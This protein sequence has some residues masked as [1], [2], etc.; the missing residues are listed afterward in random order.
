M[1][2]FEPDRALPVL[3]SPRKR[4][5]G[6][7]L[8]DKALAFSAEVSDW[9]VPLDTE[10]VEGRRQIQVRLVDDVQTIRELVL[11]LA[12][13][14]S[15]A[16]DVRFLDPPSHKPG[17]DP[18]CAHRGQSEHVRHQGGGFFPGKPTAD[19]KIP[20]G[21]ATVTARAWADGPNIWEAALALSEKK[22]PT[23][24]SVAFVNAVGLASFDTIT[25]ELT[26]ADLIE[27]GRI[28]GRVTERSVG[29]PGLAVLLADEKGYQKAATTTDASGRYAIEDVPA[30]KYRV[31]SHNS[32]TP[33][34]ADAVIE[35]K[36]G[37]LTTADLNLL[38]G[39]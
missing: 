17:A 12:L 14:R 25:I 32:A 13:D 19:G 31:L 35:V 5:I 6:F 1:V 21:A 39:R 10:G 38:Y 18:D 4:R 34:K 23:E 11:P 22:G 3:P 16:R 36:A 24:L 26:D 29:Q 27:P 7:A 37:K 9:V 15:A 8:R 20:A 30:G 2:G 28:A 33:S